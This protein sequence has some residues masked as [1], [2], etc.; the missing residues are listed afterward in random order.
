MLV[1]L[2]GWGIQDN[3]EISAIAKAKT[4][5]YDSLL[6]KYPHTTLVTHGYAV[7]LPEGQMGNSEVGHMH[8]GAGRRIYQDLVKIS[9]SF[10]DETIYENPVF[11]ETVR[12]ALEYSKPVH[13]IG[14]LS[15]GG[16]HAHIDHTI[17]MIKA[18]SNQGVAEI[19]IHAFSDGRDTDPR[20]G[21]WYIETLLAACKK[22]SVN[23]NDVKL[24]SVV[25]RYY[26]MDR[27]NRRERVEEAYDLLT[28]GIGEPTHDVLKTID[29]RYAVG[30]T[31]EFLKP[32]ICI[33]GNDDPI[34][35]IE[36]GDVVICMNYRSDRAREITKV[37]TQTI[38]EWY[39]MWPLDIEYVCMTP[40]DETF[41]DV[42]I[43]FPKDKLTQTLWEVIADAG[44]TQLRVAETEKYP[45][46]TF[47][48]SGGKEAQFEWEDR[49]LA[50][51]P[52]V[53]TYDLQPSMSAPDIARDVVAHLQ[54]QQPDFIA[55]NFA[56]PD[57]VGHTGVFEAV[58]EAVETVDSCLE[59]VVQ[60]AQSHWY[61]II[62]IADHGNADTMRNPDGSPHTQHTLNP[63]P[64]I[65]VTDEAWVSL[66]EWDL[67]DIAPTVLSRMGIHRPE[68]M[69]GKVLVR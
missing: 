16:V 8:I 7:W 21:K 43:M 17:D 9:K 44:K 32:I 60:S 38:I 42:A 23:W 66:Q 51:S 40:Y 28:N 67:T 56:N 57:M 65:L 14:L 6:V 27:D 68:S 30:E 48:F 39:D 62:V 26:A 29:A 34:A 25:G 24:A 35:L 49:I 2:D 5:Y 69:T 50:P 45:H 18:L 33:D 37:L 11:Q 59:Q 3:P 19:Y 10:E 4:P 41:R 1:I 55:I 52:K 47:F 31:D 20:S 61:E 63:V 64:C 54:K 46:V 22:Y 53:A 36:D 12:Y 13:L 15:D 58:V